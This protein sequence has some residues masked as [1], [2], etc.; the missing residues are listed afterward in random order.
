MF[1]SMQADAGGRELR[2]RGPKDAPKAACNTADR[3]VGV[4]FEVKR[5]CNFDI[6]RFPQTR[7]GYRLCCLSGG[8]YVRT[9]YVSVFIVLYLALVLPLPPP[10]P[11]FAARPCHV[12]MAMPVG[13]IPGA[14][15][16]QYCTLGIRLF[17]V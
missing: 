11:S 9:M 14:V 8:M 2:Q 3:A 13:S 17:G 6:A 1:M 7:L 10:P 12:A 15:M 5:T 4:A 16:L